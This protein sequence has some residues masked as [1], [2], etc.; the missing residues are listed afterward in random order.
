MNDLDLDDYA[1]RRLRKCPNLI[2][3]ELGKTSVFLVG[4]SLGGRIQLYVPR[5]TPKRIEGLIL[6]GT[7]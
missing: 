3:A 2:Q 4:Q 7:R 5:C 1:G 6:V